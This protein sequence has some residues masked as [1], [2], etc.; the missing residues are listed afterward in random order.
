M[1]PADRHYVLRGTWD[2]NSPRCHAMS[3]ELPGCRYTTVIVASLLA[4]VCTVLGRPEFT[5]SLRV[6]P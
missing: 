5:G 4:G 6:Y 1:E 2:W 3:R